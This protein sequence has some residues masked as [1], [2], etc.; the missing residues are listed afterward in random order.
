M[1]KLI[2]RN[3]TAAQI[4]RL[5]KANERLEKELQSM[6]DEADRRGRALNEVSAQLRAAVR[7]LAIIKTAVAEI[8]VE[9]IQDL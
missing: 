1:G 5:E 4:V 7:L 8:K 9:G 3:S 2:P 6:R